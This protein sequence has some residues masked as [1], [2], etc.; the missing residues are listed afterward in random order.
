MTNARGIGLAYTLINN[1]GPKFDPILFISTSRWASLAILND[2]CTRSSRNSSSPVTFLLPIRSIC[3]WYPTTRNSWFGLFVWWRNIAILLSIEELSDEIC[4]LGSWFE[5]LLVCGIVTMGQ[6]I[7]DLL[8]IWLKILSVYNHFNWLSRWRQVL[9]HCFFI[10]LCFCFLCLYLFLHFLRLF[11]HHIWEIDFVFIYFSRITCYFI[12]EN[13]IYNLICVAS[14]I[15]RSSND[16][17]T[18]RFICLGRALPW[19]IFQIQIV[20]LILSFFISIL[21]ASQI[22]NFIACGITH[23]FLFK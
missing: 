6:F 14:L 12:F 19:D 9:S 22:I 15:Q 11:K 2:K 3:R 21:R 1:S 10:F 13:C 16:L 18:L 4:F 23:P 20:I 5:I 7:L 17:L 8:S